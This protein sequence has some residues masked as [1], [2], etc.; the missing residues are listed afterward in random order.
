MKSHF[1]HF[2]PAMKN[3]LLFGLLLLFSSVNGQHE[4]RVFNLKEI[5]G[6]F[7][8]SN[9]KAFSIDSL[10]TKERDLELFTE[11]NAVGGVD[12]FYS[13]QA[14]KRDLL[15]WTVYDYEVGEMMVGFRIT[16]LIFD[17]KRNLVS[18]FE[19]ATDLEGG[20]YFS[21][22]HGSFISDNEY[23]L[24]QEY[25]YT[26]EEMNHAEGGITRKKI[27]IKIKADGKLK[28]NLSSL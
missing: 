21:K 22:S 3:L 13:K 11:S 14:N 16:Y 15:E 17:L 26:E 19:L 6:Q 23:V 18:S 2:Y 20:G 25:G 1:S 10:S 7:K 4:P 5:K 9:L 8:H 27:L 12:R 24:Y 28:K